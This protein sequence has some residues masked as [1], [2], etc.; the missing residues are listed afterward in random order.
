MEH[1]HHPF[2]RE[3]ETNQ[4]RTSPSRK[5]RILSL[6]FI[7]AASDMYSPASSTAPYDPAPSK[8]S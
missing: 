2:Q 4:P 6:P 3:S 8:Q 1:P 7:T 5:L